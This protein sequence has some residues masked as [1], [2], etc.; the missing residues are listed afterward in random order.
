MKIHQPSSN[1]VD[2]IFAIEKHRSEPGFGPESATFLT[3]AIKELHSS[4]SYCSVTAK[5]QL[6]YESPIGFDRLPVIR[7]TVWQDTL[8]RQM[9]H[10]RHG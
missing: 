5:T 7:G 10:V 1:P 2:G 9:D 4:P 8:P 6:G 3:A